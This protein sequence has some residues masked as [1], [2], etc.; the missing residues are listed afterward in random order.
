MSMI[1][2]L[3]MVFTSLFML[4][5]MYQNEEARDSNMIALAVGLLVSGLL[6]SLCSLA[7]VK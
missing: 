7:G 2:G 4:V 5:N 1:Y 3:C 6:T